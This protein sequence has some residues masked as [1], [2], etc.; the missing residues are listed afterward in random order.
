MNR[1]QLIETAAKAVHETMS[2]QAVIEYLDNPFDASQIAAAALTAIEAQGLAI[3]PVEAN[4][5]MR[6]AF[7]EDGKYF[8]LSYRAMIEAGKL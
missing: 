6:K 1:D 7:W 5:E 2:Q 8:S 3:V 4:D